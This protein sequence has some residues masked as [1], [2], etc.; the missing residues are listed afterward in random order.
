MAGLKVYFKQDLPL[1]TADF[2]FDYIKSRFARILQF[3]VYSE[4]SEVAGTKWRMSTPLST[5]R[6]TAEK[7]FKAANERLQKEVPKQ[8]RKE[9]GK[10]N[11]ADLDG[12]PGVEA[13][14]E[15]LEKVIQSIIQARKDYKENRTQLEKVA[16]TAGQ[17]FR[18]SYPFM[19]LLLS[20][21]KDGGSVIS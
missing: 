7:N 18:K 16:D 9:L 15:Q 19:H 2:D 5:R 4:Q 1:L 8:N 11:I 20:V 14:A 21:A 10:L 13:K 6:E 12:I 3:I 17:W